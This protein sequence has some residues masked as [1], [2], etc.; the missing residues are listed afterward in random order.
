MDIVIPVRF[1][2]LGFPSSDLPEIEYNEWTIGSSW[3]EG[4]LVDYE[5][6]VYKSVIDSNTDNPVTGAALTTPT[7]VYMGYSNYYR[8]Y[9]EGVDSVS[10]GAVDT[11]IVITAQYSEIIETIGLLNLN[12]ADGNITITDATEGVVYNQDFQITDIGVEDMWEFYFTDYEI[13]SDKTVQGLPNY[14][15]A[16]VTITINP[17]AGG[18]ASIGR[19]VMGTSY[20]VGT[21]D[22]GSRVGRKRYR[23]LT[24][25][26][27]GELTI[28]PLRY[29]KIGT[30]EVTVP[31]SR[32]DT[33]QRLFD[34]VQDVATLFLGVKDFNGLESSTSIFGIAKDFDLS[35][36]YF[37]DAL[38]SL[39]IEGY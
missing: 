31:N 8:M 14:Y 18:Q 38:Y 23:E 24:R 28:N 34:S 2:E 21:T 25:N 4:D 9:T 15:G 16:T 5:Y 37:E 35:I 30:F 26:G 22:Y 6:K 7:W 19:I 11:P 27:F 3:D 32:V 13:N 10:K 20:E 36:E 33:I 29:T 17:V 39:E 1:D 12:G